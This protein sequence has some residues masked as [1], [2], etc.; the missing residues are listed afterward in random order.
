MNP[1]RSE[2]P[3]PL[4]ASVLAEG[5][6]R[7]DVVVIAFGIA[8]ASP[9]L[10]APRAGVRVLLLERAAVPGGTTCLA[11]GHFYLGGGTPG[12]HATGHQDSAGAMYKYLTAAAKEP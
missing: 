2:I 12:Q 7:Y 6:E 4:P 9:A 5:T 3:S 1:A 10:E 11:G 8:G